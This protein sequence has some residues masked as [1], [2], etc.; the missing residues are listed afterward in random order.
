MYETHFQ[1]QLRIIAK[2]TLCCHPLH[3]I[4]IPR[5]ARYGP[6]DKFV[7]ATVPGNVAL[8]FFPLRANLSARNCCL[9][10]LALQDV[11]ALSHSALF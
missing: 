2:G 11:E 7:S 5:G 8:M 10:P 4:S 6:F 1:F 3:E 9:H